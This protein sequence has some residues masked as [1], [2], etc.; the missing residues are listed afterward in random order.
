MDE[1]G[2]KS[3]VCQG[4]KNPLVDL[5][6]LEDK[7]LDE[8]YG[9]SSLPSTS[10]LK[11]VK[12][13]SNAAI[14]KRFNHHSAMVLAAG[15]RKQETQNDVCSETGS[16]DGNSRDSDCFQPPIK[17]TKLQEAIEYEDLEKNNGR[18]TIALNLKKS[19]RYFHGPTPVQSQHYASSQDIINSLNCIRQEAVSYIPQLTQVLTSSAASSAISALSPG[20][21]LM[22]GGTQQAINQMVP[23]DIQIE[24]RHLYVAVGELLR[25]FWSCFPVNTPF[26]E[27]KVAKMKINLERFQ[28][29][30]LHPFKEKLQLQ[31]LSTNLTG[32][33]EEMLQTAYSKFHLWQS[34]R[35]LRKT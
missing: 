5:T 28:T 1:K 14:I 26:L 20:G 33:I 35:M 8:G 15:L 11:S 27:E 29:T 22:Q 10:N 31:Y 17:K 23:N 24:L 34:K 12:E 13:N 6:A 25:H 4:V 19:D 9:I 2:L 30:K 18:K 21:L 32:H 16:A 7:A 3:I